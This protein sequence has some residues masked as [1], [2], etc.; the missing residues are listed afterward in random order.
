MVEFDLLLLTAF[1]G[2]TG[3][4]EEVVGELAVVLWGFM[5]TADYL[6]ST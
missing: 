5:V 6:Y 3:E 4:C 1:H 2:P